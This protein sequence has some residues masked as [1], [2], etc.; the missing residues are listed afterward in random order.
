[1][2]GVVIAPVFSGDLVGPTIINATVV[3]GSINISFKG[4][5]LETAT[6]VDG[7]WTGTDNVSGNYTGPLGT[8]R[9][10]FYRVVRSP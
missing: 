7:E 6:S 2:P 3:G 10:K 5:E 8:N 4:G 1:M 9:L